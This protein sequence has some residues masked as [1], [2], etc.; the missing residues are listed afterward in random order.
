[1]KVTEI[2]MNDEI[3]CTAITGR[4]DEIEPTVEHFTV[5][6]NEDEIE[7]KVTGT[8]KIWPYCN[9]DN[10]YGDRGTFEGTL[11][12][13]KD[14]E[15]ENELKD[16]TLQI[17]YADVLYT[18]KVTPFEPDESATL[19]KNIEKLESLYNS[20]DFADDEF[21]WKDLFKDEKLREKV[22]EELNKQSSYNDFDNID[23]L[24]ETLEKLEIIKEDTYLGFNEKYDDT[25]GK[26]IL[27]YFINKYDKYEIKLEDGAETLEGYTDVDNENGEKFGEVYIE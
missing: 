26:I 19:S 24:V 18:F 3:I 7:I 6:E 10:D 17:D 2:L 23:L 14:E 4:F 8:F 16:K 13:D 9:Y 5:K 15:Y 21:L 11:T 25:F 12:I 1:M 20:I 22:I 27:P